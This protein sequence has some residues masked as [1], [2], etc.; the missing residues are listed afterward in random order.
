MR[1]AKFRRIGA[2]LLALALVLVAAFVIYASQPDPDP[3]KA[4]AV[5]KR[6]FPSLTY[7]IQGFFW[8]DTGYVGMQLDWVKM[9]SFNTIKQTF[10]WRD[11]E[12][13]R[14]VWTF[15]AAD[16]LLEETERRHLHVIARLGQTPIWAGG[17]EGVDS[18]MAKYDFPP[19][20]LALWENYCR[21]ISE[22]YA[23]RITAYQIWNEPNL[24]REWGNRPP[25]AAEYTEVLRICSTAIRA[26][27]PNA[28]IISAG[29]APTG[30]LDDTAHRDDV[31]LDAMYRA[32]FQHYVDVVGVH[33][34]GYSAPTYGPD[35]A[36]QAGRGRWFAF[37]RVEDLR[38]IMIQHGDAARQMAILEMGWTVDQIHPDY[39]WF[40]VTEQQQAQYMVE[41]YEYIRANWS[42][43]V[44]LVSMI[45]LPRATWTEADEEYW[46]S[47]ATPQ[48][49]TRPV[50]GALVKMP[51]YCDDYVIPERTDTSEEGILAT[52]NSCP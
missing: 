29:L 52:L 11:M 1:K 51:K 24:S 16:K 46:W 28:I 48:N 47:I 12:P 44:G 19:E 35:D 31:Y 10:A 22:R 4:A 27:D 37:R 34:P 5:T 43:W 25:D 39:A 50:F 36:E 8:W 41:A 6:P 30:N 32:G 13:E 17:A 9:M 7:S 38:K 26:A 33:A 15:H 49:G 2:S 23:G 18:E 14:D 3:F 42:P 40:A 45:Y 21:T 20:D